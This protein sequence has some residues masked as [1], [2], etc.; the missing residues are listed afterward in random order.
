VSYT[1][2]PVT[3]LEGTWGELVDLFLAFEDYNR[4]FLRRRLR[5]DWEQRWRAHLTHGDGRLILLARAADEAI[6]YAVVE[7]VRDHGLYDEAHA[8]LSD[9]FVRAPYRDRGVGR[10]LVSHITAW[11][12]ERDVEEVRIDV[13]AANKP[14]VR[15]WTYSGYTLDSMQMK[16]TLGP[17]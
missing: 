13:F 15:F 10:A 1:I 9:L 2:E 3:D 14:G 8:Y 17:S 12:R 11:A 16:K 5:D 4:G 7:V 6:G